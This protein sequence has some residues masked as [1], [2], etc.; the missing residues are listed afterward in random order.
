MKNKKLIVIIAVIAVALVALIWGGFRVVEYTQQ[1]SIRNE[2][3]E[4]AKEHIETDRYFTP[5]Y[6]ELLS[7]EAREDMPTLIEDS[8]FEEYYMTFDCKTAK[9]GD[10]V[11]RVHKWYDGGWIFKHV[12]H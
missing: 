2:F 1:Q 9:G 7:F 4:A 10:V 3:I 8:P 11:I 5:Q 6:G 12:I